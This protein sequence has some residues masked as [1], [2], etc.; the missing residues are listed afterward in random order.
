MNIYRHAARLRKVN[1]GVDAG[2]RSSSI[3]KFDLVESAT[4]VG[5]LAGETEH[6]SSS[7]IVEQNSQKSLGVHPGR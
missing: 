3:I 2:D 5:G 1:A 6:S 4:F 7:L